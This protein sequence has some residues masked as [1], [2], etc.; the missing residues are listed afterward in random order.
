VYV[1]PNYSKYVPR[2]ERENLKQK[3]ILGNSQLRKRCRGNSI[4]FMLN[5][6]HSK[7]EKRNNPALALR[8]QGTPGTDSKQNASIIKAHRTF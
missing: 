8:T 4:A 2:P 5:D 1:T 6:F 7:R 3:A